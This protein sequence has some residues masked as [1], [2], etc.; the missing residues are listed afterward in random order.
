MYQFCIKLYFSC[1]LAAWAADLLGL[2]GLVAAGLA[3]SAAVLLP[4]PWQQGQRQ[5]RQ[6]LLR[7]RLGEREWVLLPLGGSHS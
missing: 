5:A 6:A 4:A 7:Q 2:L 3:T 1:L